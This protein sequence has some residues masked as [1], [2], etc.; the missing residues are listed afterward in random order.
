[1]KI[2]IMQPYFM[3]YIGYFQLL[4]SVDKFIFLDDVNFI[5]SG[6][7]NRNRIL[8]NNKE[9]LFTIPLKDASSNR[10]I[11]KTEINQNLFP[12][13]KRKFLLSIQYSYSNA[14]FYNETYDLICYIFDKKHTFISSLSIA[15]IEAISNYLE[16]STIFETSSTNYSRSMGEEKDA[17]LIEICKLNEAST[18]INPSGGKTLYDKLYFKKH[19]IELFFIEN[20]ITPYNQFK[21][22]FIGG[23]S[24]LDVMMFNS[25]RD[26]K[27]MLTKY[28]IA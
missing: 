1:M 26:I 28:K 23:L 16:I 21:T 13:W 11:Y 27:K 9:Y 18:Y 20:E 3:P 7:I 12:K 19:D 8:L 2:G 17:R 4:N 25:T 6:W 15:S 10:L 24:I 5:K 14:P 22:P